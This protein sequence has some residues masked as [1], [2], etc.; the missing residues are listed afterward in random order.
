MR[1][2]DVSVLGDPRGPFLNALETEGVALVLW[3]LVVSTLDADVV[4]R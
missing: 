2:L 4:F 1:N 3:S